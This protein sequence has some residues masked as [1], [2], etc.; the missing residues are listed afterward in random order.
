MKRIHKINEIG[1]PSEVRESFSLDCENS[2]QLEDN[3]EEDELYS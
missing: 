2:E 3:D 1:Y